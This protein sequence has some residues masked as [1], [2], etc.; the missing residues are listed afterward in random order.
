MS[1]ILVVRGQIYP[2]RMSIQITLVMFVSNF[3]NGKMCLR[4]SESTLS[5]WQ[6][7][8]IPSKYKTHTLVGN[9]KEKKRT[10]RDNHRVCLWQR[11]YVYESS[12]KIREAPT[13]VCSYWQLAT[14]VNGHHSFPEGH[15]LQYFAMLWSMDTHP[16]MY[17][18]NRS[19][20]IDFKKSMR[21][22]ICVDEK[23]RSSWRRWA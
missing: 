14:A 4:Y 1:F 3:W 13:L 20:W 10:S 21:K 19:D 17:S 18:Q 5:V 6:Q 2:C 16:K 22:Q 7:E 23:E 9:K 12:S 15:G 8:I 11:P